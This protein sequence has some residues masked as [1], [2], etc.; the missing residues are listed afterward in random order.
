MLVKIEL[1]DNK[2]IWNIKNRVKLTAHPVHAAKLEMLY[3]LVEVVGEPESSISL[4][5]M[6]SR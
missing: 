3:E 1:A 4:S 2:R 6:S 5:M